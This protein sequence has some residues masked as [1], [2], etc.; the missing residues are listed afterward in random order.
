MVENGTPGYEISEPLHK[1]GWKA[2]DTRALSFADCAVPDG[3]L[4]GPRGK[5]FH[6][7]LE[8]LDGGRI[9]VAAM[10]VGLAQGAYDLAF[11]Y[12]RERHQFGR[13]ISSFQAIQFKLADMAT[14]IEAARGSSGRRPGSRIGAARSRSRRR[15]RSST[16]ASSRTASSTRR[17]RSTAA[18]ASWTSS[19]IS[20]LYRDQKI[21]EIGEGTNEVQR[22]VIARHL[23]L[24]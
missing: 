9:S 8:I 2:S 10:G 13:P 19:P 5:G 17:C 6:Q 22:M 14:E 3:N 7:F 4:L 24:P 11:A 12:A 21:L 1:L 23:G 18:T 16:P 15:W 20:R